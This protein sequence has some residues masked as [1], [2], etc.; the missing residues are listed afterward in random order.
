M[1]TTAMFGSIGFST[2]G[3]FCLKRRLS[4]S[5]KVRRKNVNGSAKRRLEVGK[6]FGDH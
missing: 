6:E 2:L 3:W 1:K 4:D 5:H